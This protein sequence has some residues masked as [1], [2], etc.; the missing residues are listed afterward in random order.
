MAPSP[1]SALRTVAAA[2]IVCALLGTGAL[3]APADA[4]PIQDADATVQSLRRDADAAA[5]EYFDALSRANALDTRI[6]A[7]GGEAPRARGP[8][9]QATTA[10]GA[11]CRG[12]VRSRRARSSPRCSTAATR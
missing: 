6:A 3:V 8:P 2:G 12:R 10:R 11:P 1:S 7:P 4:D 9:A 5:Q